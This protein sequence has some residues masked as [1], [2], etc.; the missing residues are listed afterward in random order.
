MHMVTIGG[1][2]VTAC[3]YASPVFA[4]RYLCLPVRPSA[5]LTDEEKPLSQRAPGWTTISNPVLALA[6]SFS[7]MR[8]GSWVFEPAVTATGA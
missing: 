4:V 2:F 1:L 6:R 8:S 3:V 5:V 7:V